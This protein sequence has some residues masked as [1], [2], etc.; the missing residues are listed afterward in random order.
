[1][2]LTGPITEHLTW[3][4][5]TRTDHRAFLDLQNPPPTD[6]KQHIEWFA[7][8][9]FEP[10]RALLGPLI[11][12]SLYRC[13]PLN[14]AIGGSKTSRHVL[15]LACDLVPVRHGLAEAFSLMARRE[16]VWADQ[17][18]YEYGRWLHLGAPKPGDTP[19]GQLLMIF[20]AGKYLPWNPADTRITWRKA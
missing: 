18:I 3:E 13:A 17:L 10:A 20:E 9:Y 7:R 4:E 19:R 1:M 5:A 14:E 8:H 6:V 16:A 2:G 12:N 11:V 15:G